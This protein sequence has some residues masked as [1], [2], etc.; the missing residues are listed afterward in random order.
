M[1]DEK[2]LCPMLAIGR[3]E[4]E[5]EEYA[6]CMEEHCA[7]WLPQYNNRMP[8]TVVG[9]RCALSMLAYQVWNIADK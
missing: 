4:D 5:R 7:W 2:K 8:R 9:G 1:D 6:V 3:A